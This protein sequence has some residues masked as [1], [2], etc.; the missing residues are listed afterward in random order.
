MDQITDQAN[1][2]IPT[3]P[4]ENNNNNDSTER[5]TEQ[6][7]SDQKNSKNDDNPNLKSGFK[8]AFVKYGK[9][10]SRYVALLW[11]TAPRGTIFLIII[12]LAESLVPAVA[13]SINKQVV[14]TVAALTPGGDINWLIVFVIISLWI[15]IVVLENISNPWVNVASLNLAD[16]LT[17]NIN[18]KLM[19]KAD[20][21]VDITNFEDTEF[22]DKLSILQARAG[23]EP[24]GILNR[25]LKV[26]SQLITLITMLVLLSTVSLW[27]PLLIV[28]TYLP[29]TFASFQIELEIWNTTF[30]KSSQVRRMSYY[31]N[32]MLTDTYA[33][34]VRLFGLYPLFNQRYLEAFED[35][36]QA[37]KKLRSKQATTV[38]V[39][40]ILSTFGNGFCFGWVILQAVSGNLTAG[41]ILLLIQSLAYIQSNITRISQLS[42]NMQRSML[43]LEM[44]FKFMD[45]KPTMSVAI[46]GE[47]IPK[48]IESGITFD[49]VDFAYPDGR[50]VLSGISLTLNP[51]E[52][53]ALV[54]ENGA[55]KSTLV[56]LLARFYD[57]TQGNISVD[58]KNIKDL[59][60]DD[61]RKKIGV[62]FQDFC[63]YSLTVGENI[64]LGDIKAM[65]D[66][67]K[68]KDVSQK[69][70][71]LTQIEQLPSGYKTL[72]GKQFDGTELSG[73]QW[74]KIAIARAFMREQD[75]QLM[76]LDEP[77]AAL[78][79]RSEYEIYS[80]FTKLVK[81][82][83]AILVTHRLASV[84][85][86][87]RILVL[88]AGKLIEIGTHEELLQK[89]GEYATLWKMQAEQYQVN[90]S[91]L[92]TSKL[93]VSK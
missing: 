35:K 76:I 78:D 48:S 86:A 64:A 75:A 5:N 2:S 23:S 68:L 69:S 12:L 4:T 9:L 13:V 46:P 26:F 88:K 28:A 72:L 44:L 11:E 67:E 15:F 89:K 31:S 51:G 59:N 82:K 91:E 55:G 27:I 57:P 1:E 36:H 25:L 52:T 3:N 79:P 16:E 74:Q 14:D 6:N 22:Y 7:Y 85:L 47:L 83:I 38:T 37:L 32:L 34:E 80:S 19:E 92:T 65:N 90:G 58:G 41:S 81:D 33:K 39:L 71:V 43:F 60:L 8:Q 62:V 84:R 63:H 20:S 70:E 18:L 21:F 17:A 66:I 50:V 30:K 45:T 24:F 73:G 49:N 54:G 10:F 77:T 29:Q 40:G 56:K 53:V 61:W 87:D 93:T 42:L